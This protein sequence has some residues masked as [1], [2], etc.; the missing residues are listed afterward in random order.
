MATTPLTR[1]DP[2]GSHWLP[3]GLLPPNFEGAMAMVEGASTDLNCDQAGGRRVIV[4]L[5]VLL[6]EDSWLVAQELKSIL[7]VMGVIVSGPAATIAEATQ[8]AEAGLF[9]AAIVDMNLQGQMAYNLVDNLRS[10]GVPVV[11]ITGY[12][13]LPSLANKGV[14][15]LKKPLR[16]E[17]LLK[18]L[19]GIAPAV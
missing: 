17:A 4:G 18:T 11:V 2:D 8:L 12:E 15:I 14:P 10:H 13:V 3:P 7:E 1:T 16:A 5:R 6:V 9:D 19:R